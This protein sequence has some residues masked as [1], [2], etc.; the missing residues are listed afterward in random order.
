MIEAKYYRVD[1]EYIQQSALLI[2]AQS[3]E[4]ANKLVL[5]S[6][7]PTVQGFKVNSTTEISE[8]EKDKML[9]HGPDEERTLN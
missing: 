5:D 2:M 6:V 7:D 1:F 4:E 3:P 9:R 8:E